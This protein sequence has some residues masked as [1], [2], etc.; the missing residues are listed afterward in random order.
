MHIFHPPVISPQPYRTACWPGP[1]PWNDPELER[2]RALERIADQELEK[3]RI[4]AK[5]RRVGYPESVITPIPL[6]YP[7]P[8][9]MRPLPEH[10]RV[11]P[12]A[13][14]GEVLR[15]VG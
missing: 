14:I 13:S 11:Q 4:R 5:L 7:L 2:L 10:P 8:P 1:F 6:P 9:I 15:K 12:P 3:Q